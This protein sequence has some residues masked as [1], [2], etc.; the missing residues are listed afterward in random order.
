MMA[1]AV[2]SAAWCAVLTA[3][4]ILVVAAGGAVSVAEQRT[5]GCSETALP[6]AASGRVN[7]EPRK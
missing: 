4:V 6:V 1:S 3:A 2:S 7:F 5:G